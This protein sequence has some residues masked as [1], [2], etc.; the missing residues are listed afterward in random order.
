MLQDRLQ[1][2]RVQKRVL[3]EISQHAELNLENILS[4]D[5]PTPESRDSFHPATKSLCCIFSN[6]TPINNMYGSTSAITGHQGMVAA[7]RRKGSR[8]M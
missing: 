1:V 5:M 4:K 2:T 7:S 8:G 3:H 6:F